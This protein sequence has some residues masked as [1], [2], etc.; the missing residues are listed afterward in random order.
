MHA[1]CSW[2]LNNI[3]L[4][5]KN[6]H[7]DLIQ[8]LQRLN[9]VRHIVRQTRDRSES[10]VLCVNCEC[11]THARWRQMRMNDY[12]IEWFS[13]YQRRRRYIVQ[14]LQRVHFSI[15]PDHGATR[16]RI[17]KWIR[18]KRAA[19][20]RI[21]LRNQIRSNFKTSLNTLQEPLALQLCRVSCL[22]LERSLPCDL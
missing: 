15:Q 4:R 11:C 14:G 22:S 13:F 8:R 21:E 7:Y 1:S 6:L 12:M 18:S 20:G 10:C 5:C 17:E 16:T 2:Q 19:R 3:C 9:A